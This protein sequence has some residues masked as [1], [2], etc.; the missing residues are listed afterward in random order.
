MFFFVLLFR[1][2]R[3]STF[4]R[5][6]F[7]S[8]VFFLCR[9][10]RWKCHQ[11]LVILCDFGSYNYFICGMRNM[12]S[13]HPIWVNKAFEAK[14]NP[15]KTHL[16]VLF[17]KKTLFFFST[18]LLTQCC[19]SIL[20]F[21]SCHCV[22]KI[23][24]TFANILNQIQNIRNVETYTSLLNYKSLAK[25]AISGFFPAFN[26]V[27]YITNLIFNSEIK[28]VR[29]LYFILYLQIPET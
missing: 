11:I 27:A 14:K 4:T 18:S 24:I 20:F 6:P 15:T 8:I 7:F 9:F 10:F 29:G 16:L 12:H 19:W 13:R 5:I 1:T 22:N 26:D 2:L 21:V 17:E 23:H 25:D 3:N 28:F